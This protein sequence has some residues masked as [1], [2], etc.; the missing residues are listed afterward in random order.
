MAAIDYPEHKLRISFLVSD[1][2]GHIAREIKQVTGEQ[3]NCH[4]NIE[5]IEVA[6]NQTENSLINSI[7]NFDDSDVTSVS[8]MSTLLSTDSLLI[9]AAQ[10]NYR[11]TGIVCGQYHFAHTLGLNQ[12]ASGLIERYMTRCSEYSFPEL[13]ADGAFYAFRTELFRQ[14]CPTKIKNDLG[15]S[16]SIIN[17]GY[18]AIYDPRI[19]SLETRHAI[20]MDQTHLMLQQEI[21]TCKHVYRR[22]SF[23]NPGYGRI[24]FHYFSWSFL[25]LATPFFVLVII[26]TAAFLASEYPFFQSVSYFFSVISV[27]SLISLRSDKSSSSSLPGKIIFRLASYSRVFLAQIYLL[28]NKRNGSLKSVLPHENIR[29]SST[30]PKEKSI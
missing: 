20:E 2:T 17:Y 8:N 29:S 25:R 18:Q 21:A 3:Q 4:L 13:G 9:T 30:Q 15:I 5:V 27:L 22:L 28:F 6:H 1:C 12:K 10:L 23:L 16:A 11:E 26:A 7:L 24:F 14:L 19:I